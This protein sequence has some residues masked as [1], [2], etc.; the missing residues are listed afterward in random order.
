MF[1][2]FFLLIVLFLLYIQSRKRQYS[3]VAG[4]CVP[5]I[6]IFVVIC[7]YRVRYDYLTYYTLIENEEE[8]QILYLFSPLSILWAE[9]ALYFESP[10]M[11]FVLFGLPTFALLIFTLKKYSK[12]YA[13]SVTI[14]ICFFF[15]TS[16]S[17]IRQALALAICFYGYRFIVK[18]S[19]IKYILCILIAALFHPSAGVAIIIYWLPFLKFRLVVLLSIISIV[20]KPLFFYMLNILGVY[21][22]YLDGK[23]DIEGGKYTQLIYF[24]L[25]IICF[26]LGSKNIDKN[27]C[28][29][30]NVLL[31]SFVFV[32]FL[33]AHLGGRI[34]FYFNIYYCLLIPKVVKGL[35]GQLREQVK[36]LS[37]FLCISY[38][39]LYLFVPFIKGVPSYYIPY[40]F[41][42]FK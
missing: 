39:L 34:A 9:T 14:L 3:T 6:I 10:Q 4:I 7:R 26:V 33:G 17:I 2:L 20:A 31:L 12:D 19:L 24:L 1:Y 42:F 22:S 32:S 15:F 18:R 11:L 29:L 16:L 36:L 8:A 30:F 25:F 23:M 28:N 13:L 21:T 40:K 35:D 41:I 38:F 5:I 27:K 37:Y